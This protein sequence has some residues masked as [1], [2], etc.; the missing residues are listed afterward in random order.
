[1]TKPLLYCRCSPG[2]RFWRERFRLLGDFVTP[3]PR[4]LWNRVRAIDLPNIKIWQGVDGQWWMW[5]RGGYEWDGASMVPTTSCTVL[6]SLIH[7]LF[8]DY[9][10]EV[11]KV[12]GCSRAD[13]RGFADDWFEYVLRNERSWARRIYPWGVRRFGG[14]WNEVGLWIRG[15]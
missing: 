12:W 5:V 8:Y 11:S 10:T 1:M 3:I 13:V 2:W 7:D 15:R 4:H 9:V 6:A 14:L